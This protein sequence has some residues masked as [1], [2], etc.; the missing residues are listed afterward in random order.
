MSTISRFDVYEGNVVTTLLPR[1]E[2]PVYRPPGVFAFAL[3]D[4]QTSEYYRE[5]W[6]YSVPRSLLEDDDK[7]KNDQGWPQ[8]VP[9]DP[10]DGVKLTK[11][12][13]WFIIKQLVLA[14]YGIALIEH[15][16][17]TRLVTIEEEFYKRLTNEQQAYIKKAWS[18]L[19]KSWTAFMNGKGT[20]EGSGNRDY[21]N[22]WNLEGEFAKIFELCCGGNLLQ[23]ASN[24]KYGRG[25]KVLTL[26]AADYWKWKHWTFL[27][28]PQFFM[29]ATNATPF[30]RGT[31]DTL[32]NTGP[33]KVD[34]MHYLDGAH[35]PLPIFSADGYVYAETHRVRILRADEPTPPPYQQ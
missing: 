16:S 9:F 35:V 11:E 34:P 2:P 28:H 15:Y 12:L 7:L 33:W 23:L 30:L 19:T 3:N 24:V 10:R 20:E 18:G 13:Q 6:G 5:D 8:I 17:G 14:K 4:Y 29:L 31:R 1:T 27:D 22:G 26:R 32:T 21:I 25:Y